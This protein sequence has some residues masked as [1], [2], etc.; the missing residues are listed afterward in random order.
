MQTRL[1]RLGRPAAAVV[2]VLGVLAAAPAPVGRMSTV[3]LIVTAADTETA[4]SAVR[5]VGGRVLNE[6]TVLGGVVADVPAGVGLP[7]GVGSSPDRKVSLR[8]TDTDSADAASSVRATLGLDAGGNE[9]AGITVAV[10]DTGVAD[11]ADLAAAVEHVNLTGGAAGDGYGH[12]TFMAGLIAGSGASSGGAF[13][14]VAP[15]ARI[16]D[17]KVADNAGNT[18]LVTVLRGLEVV[19][20]HPEVRVLNLSLSS[21]SPLP[22]QADPL[23]RMLDVLWARGVVV[24]VPAGNDGPDSG[25]VTSPGTD[26]NLLTVGGL[27]EAATGDRSDDT[28]GPWSS[29]G[30][31]P[32]GVD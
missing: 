11:V 1:A 27:D 4:A 22:Y 26:P 15:G 24:V 3:R 17:V 31:A 19:A 2:A 32:Q 13:R 5:S 9:G 14:G 18:S 28:I 23:T 7:A 16:L 30:P 25:T 10:V 20:A 12:G 21:D 6:L 29:R 8:S